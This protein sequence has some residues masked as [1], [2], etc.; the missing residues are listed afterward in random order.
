M[1]YILVTGASGDIGEACVTHL[2]KNGYSIYC[3]YFKNKERVTQLINKL[4]E[5]Y[6]NQDF[7][8]LQADLTKPSEVSQITD[9]LFQ[10]NG[11]VFAHGQTVYQLLTDTTDEELMMLWNSHVH[12]PVR[13]CQL[14]QS[15][16][17][18]HDS[19]QII[20]ISSVYGLIGSSMEVMYS[21]VKGAQ[22]AFVKAYAKEVA[23]MSLT[24]N[25]IAPGAV[26]TQMNTSWTQDEKQ[27]LLLD[28][29][30]N[31]MAKPSEIASLVNYL[32]G[33]DAT[34]ITGTTIPLAGG[35]S[36]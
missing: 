1:K 11:L 18:T 26:D 3:H 34:Y 10:L 29:P 22:L 8:A 25:A 2:A 30:L 28:I 12:S 4:S 21:T 31:R 23:S 17:V 7:F 27:E 36:I 24:V 14:C 5:E 9:N 15:K 6:P 35:W 20:F 19:S 32:L 16:L 33:A 13:I